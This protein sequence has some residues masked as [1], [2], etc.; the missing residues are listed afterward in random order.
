MPCLG[1]TGHLDGPF[2]QVRFLR[3]FKDLGVSTAT[4]GP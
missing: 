1:T 2:N 4:N 3:V